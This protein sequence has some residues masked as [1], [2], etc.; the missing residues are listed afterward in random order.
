MAAERSAPHTGHR[1]NDSRQSAQIVSQG[2]RTI[3]R[4]ARRSFGIH[5]AA[6]PPFACAAECL[7][8]TSRAQPPSPR[9]YS[10]PSFRGHTPGLTTRPHDCSGRQFP[11]SITASRN[12]SRNTGT[13]QAMVFI[14]VGWCTLRSATHARRS[15]SNAEPPALGNWPSEAWQ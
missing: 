8:T 7:H 1:T 2:A 9:R 12:C 10:R 11:P 15:P 5:F 6:P 3:S 13:P 14:A 4:Q